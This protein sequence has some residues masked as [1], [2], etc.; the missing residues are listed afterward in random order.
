MKQQ[1]A[2]TYGSP[3]TVGVEVE[4]PAVVDDHVQREDVAQ[5]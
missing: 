2:L 1:T 3:F 4:D 5:G